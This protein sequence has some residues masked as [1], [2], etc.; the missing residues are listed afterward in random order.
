MLSIETWLGAQPHILSDRGRAPRLLPCVNMR[1]KKTEEGRKRDR[2]SEVERL[3]SRR[4]WIGGDQW[5]CWTVERICV[6]AISKTITPGSSD[7]GTHTLLLPCA[8]LRLNSFS[9]NPSVP[10]RQ[11]SADAG[12]K[13]R[14]ANPDS[15]LRHHYWKTSGILT[16]T[17]AATDLFLHSLWHLMDF[18][19]N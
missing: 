16:G 10:R 8:G 19:G 13:Q 2:E 14:A 17:Q 1:E 11:T 15:R 4:T 7:C 18:C 3:K 12:P 6:T 9:E 5:R